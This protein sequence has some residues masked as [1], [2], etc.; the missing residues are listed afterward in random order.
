MFTLAAQPQN[1]VTWVFD[2]LFSRLTG[3]KSTEDLSHNWL[4]IREKEMKA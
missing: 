1:D 2:F 4:N 3:G